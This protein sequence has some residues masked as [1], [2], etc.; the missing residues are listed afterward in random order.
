MG[1]TLS[2]CEQAGVDLDL[3]VFMPGSNKEIQTDQS[4][5]VYWHEQ[6]TSASTYSIKLDFDD[7]GVGENLGDQQGNA[8]SFGPESIHLKGDLPE[9]TYAIMVHAYSGNPSST[10]AGKCPLISLYSTTNSAMDAA[11]PVEY[12]VVGE[13]GRNGNWWHVMNLIVTT[14]G[15][16]TSLFKKLEFLLVKVMMTSNDF[17]ELIGFENLLGLLNYFPSEMKTK[18][19]EKMLNFFCSSK[20]KLDDGFLIH[21]IFQVAKT[22]HDKIDS[23]SE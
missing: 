2:W 10:L 19:C 5:A 9:G 17:S 4:H 12:L 1:L 16:G 7:E 22:L 11:K 18:L 20:D 8:R 15:T 13:K 6:S 21:S 23:M 14:V 3:W